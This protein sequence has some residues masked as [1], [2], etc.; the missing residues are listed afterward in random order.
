MKNIKLVLLKKLKIHEKINK[1]HL[2]EV[3]REIFY[4][5]QIIDPI[6]VDLKTNVILD[7]HHRVK[8]LYKNGY[9]KAPVFYVNYFDN[10]IKLEQRRKNIIISKEII[11]ERALN[12]NP[13]PHKTSKHII[14]NLPKIKNIF[15][16]D[17]K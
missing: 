5:G 8:I 3:E 1:N 12:N 13:F 10:N 6:I 11:I 14:P 16:K 9:S 7:G 4:L 2:K 17:L 15:L